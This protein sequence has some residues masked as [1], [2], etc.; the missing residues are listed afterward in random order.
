MVKCVGFLVEIK[1]FEFSI[2]CIQERRN[3]IMLNS[4]TFYLFYSCSII[5]NMQTEMMICLNAQQFLCSVDYSGR[6][7]QVDF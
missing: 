7:V 5:C 4:A 3:I 2:Q 1:I 6:L